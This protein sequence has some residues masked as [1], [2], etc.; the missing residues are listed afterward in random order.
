[1]REWTCQYGVIR[2]GRGDRTRGADLLVQHY[3]AL[4]I[5]RR[6]DLSSSRSA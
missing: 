6:Q 2:S 3:A 1:M 4:G 5:T